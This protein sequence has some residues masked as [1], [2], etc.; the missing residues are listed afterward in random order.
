MPC[1][2]QREEEEPIAHC[3]RRRRQRVVQWGVVASPVEVMKP[4]DRLLETMA[5]ES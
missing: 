4:Y 3:R 5:F 2:Y 1:L